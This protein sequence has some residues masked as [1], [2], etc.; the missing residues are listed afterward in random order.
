VGS[1][2]WQWNNGCGDPHQVSDPGAAAPD[3]VRQYRVTRCVDGA[4][5]D[6]GV[7]PEWRQV[8][9]RPAVRFAPG[10]MTDVTSDSSAGTLDL[11]ATDATPGAQVELWAPGDQAPDVGGTGIARVDSVQSGRGWHIT[12]ETCAPDYHVLLGQDAGPVPDRCA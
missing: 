2:W 10:W 11:R 6:A 8:L 9:T 7:V 4:A 5:E 1:A 12:A 3:E